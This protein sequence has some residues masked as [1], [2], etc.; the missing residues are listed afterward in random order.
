MKPSLFVII[1][2]VSILEV[3][4]SLS[5]GKQGKHWTIYFGATIQGGLAQL[6]RR[7]EGDQD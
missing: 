7:N 4:N 3:D 2:D 6:F 1:V 5:G